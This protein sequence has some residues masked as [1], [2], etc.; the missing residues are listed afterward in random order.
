MQSPARI[1]LILAILA[2]ALTAVGTFTRHW[3]HAEH[4]SR[5]LNIGLR[6][7]QECYKGECE[8]ATW[9]E[10]KGTAGRSTASTVGPIAFFLGI[11][12]ALVL[13]LLAGAIM[14]SPANVRTIGAVALGVSTAFLGLTLIY[15][16]SFPSGFV[17]VSWSAYVAWVAAGIGITA[18]ALSLRVRSAR[19]IG[20]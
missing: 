8:A 11:G 10:V 16:A 7:W 9:S 2:T 12:A 19:A 18:G 15:I 13:A 17:P 3:R 6:T 1:I 4:R 14:F 5:E 20:A